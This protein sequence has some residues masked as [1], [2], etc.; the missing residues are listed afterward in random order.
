MFL[1]KSSGKNVNK[2]RNFGAGVESRMTSLS[3]YLKSRMWKY[4]L[5]SSHPV[6]D[7]FVEGWS[8]K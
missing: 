1:I 4:S 2:K 8:I 7:Q 3:P 6:S 5:V